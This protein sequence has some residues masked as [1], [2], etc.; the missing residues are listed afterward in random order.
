MTEKFDL[1]AELERLRKKAVEDFIADK[2]VSEN[3]SDVQKGLVSGWLTEAFNKG[4][5]LGQQEA[6]ALSPEMKDVMSE[7]YQKFFANSAEGGTTDKELNDEAVFF[8]SMFF[9]QK[10]IANSQESIIREQ[11]YQIGELL[12]KYKPKAEEPKNAFA[13]LSSCVDFAKV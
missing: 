6:I 7:I 13:A 4:F 1:K 9:H 10:M 5:E 12:Q 11:G 3:F 8:R 2:T